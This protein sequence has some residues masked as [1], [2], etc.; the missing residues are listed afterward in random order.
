M[1]DNERTKAKWSLD[2]VLLKVSM[3]DGEAADFNLND[4]FSGFEKLTGTQQ[5]TIAYGVKQKLSDSTARSKDEKLDSKG[6]IEVMRTTY[7]GIVDGTAWTKK[8][9]GGFSKKISQAVLEEK[10]KE[11]GLSV[12]KAKAMLESIGFTI[13]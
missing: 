7:A 9:G 3:P 13:N 4:L 1:A 8:G 12:T 6:A 10:A 2:K 11:A 5:N